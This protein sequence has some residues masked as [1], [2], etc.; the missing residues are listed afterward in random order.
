MKHFTKSCKENRLNTIYPKQM[1]KKIEKKNI[2]QQNNQSYWTSVGKCHHL[3]ICTSFNSNDILTQLKVF[4][5]SNFIDF[6]SYNIS[7][8]LPYSQFFENSIYYFKL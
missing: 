3:Q 6:N 4:A 7:S 8:N 2:I 5:F 1:K